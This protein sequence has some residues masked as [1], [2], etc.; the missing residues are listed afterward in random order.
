VERRPRIAL[1][2]PLPREL[3]TSRLPDVEVVVPD[4]DVR[5]ACAGATAVIAD[6]NGRTVVDA[7]TVDTLAPTCRLIQVPAAGLDGVD[8]DAV[9]AAGITL[10]T[11]AG[12]NAVAVAE[13]C[14]WAAI[15]GLRQLSAADRAVRADGWPQ[16]GRARYELAGQTVGLVGLGRV[17]IE[18]ARRLAPFGVDLRYH[19]RHRRDV[20][21]EEELG[22][23]W[24]ELDELVGTAQVLVLACAST[25]A[26]RG[27]LDAGRIARLPRGAVVVNAARGE[28]VD[29]PALRDAV[30]RGD[31]HA[32][33][34]DVYGTEPPP[35]EHPLRGHDAITTT[36]H[37]A[38]TSA[39]AVGRIGR[40]VTDNL[41]AVLAGREP[42]GRL[43]PTPD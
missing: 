42:E 5:T 2:A 20:G 4:P 41:A 3:I 22:V 19:S 14:V 16:L 26:T 9:H 13:W 30:G 33:V 28:V 43:A 40:R 29:E 7:A 35:A 32:V 15:D 24:A 23:R 21:V 6:W 12:L 36:P 18:V 38:G 27:L 25:P 8:V 37:V 10:A 39:Q 34:T 31:L 1:L 11:C 17:G